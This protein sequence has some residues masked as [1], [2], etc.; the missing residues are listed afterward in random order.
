MRKLIVIQALLLS[1]LFTHGQ[2]FIGTEPT[3]NPVLLE[4]QSIN[5]GVLIPRINIPDTL[6]ASPVATPQKGL[7]VTNIAP[8][9]EGLYFWNGSAWE[10]LK[11]RKSVA[12]DL[13]RLGKKIIFIGEA[14]TSPMQTI[15]QNGTIDVLLDS[16]LGTLGEN[17][18]HQIAEAGVYEIMAS[19]TG[20]PSGRDGFIVLDIHDHQ[21]GTYLARTTVSQSLS[22]VDIGAKAVYCGQLPAGSRIGL[23]VFYGSGSTAPE[24]VEA[25]V[26]SIKKIGV[27]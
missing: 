14:K 11:T 8:G 12:S 19:L 10:K 20:E 26:L 23:R 27:N 21:Q 5:R 16:H 7:L 2:V 3:G 1:A 17:K 4:V 25:A 22:F 13:T 6:N 15:A 24:G 9:K 18:Y